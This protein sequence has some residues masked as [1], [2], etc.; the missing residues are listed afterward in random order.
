MR[1]KLT[2]IRLN[3][4]NMIK[5]QNNIMGP[6][7]HPAQLTFYTDA[8]V[9]ASLQLAQSFLF[10][11]LPRACKLGNDLVPKGAVRRKEVAQTFPG[12]ILQF[13]KTIAS[14]TRKYLV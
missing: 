7:L 10:P 2:E 8:W 5:T 3:K 14:Q 9:V 1:R 12:A 4:K 11:P 6:I 13:Q